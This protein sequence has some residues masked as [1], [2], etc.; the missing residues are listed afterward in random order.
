[1]RAEIDSRFIEHSRNLNS[2]FPVSGM[3]IGSL[4]KSIGN[5]NVSQMKFVK[6][7]ITFGW[8]NFNLI[9]TR[10]PF[11]ANYERREM[12]NTIPMMTRVKLA[13]KICFNFRR[14]ELMKRFINSDDE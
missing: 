11:G 8:R 7:F 13:Q 9:G 12:F 3:L 1:M 6:K 4:N 5:F 14:F 2:A 10:S